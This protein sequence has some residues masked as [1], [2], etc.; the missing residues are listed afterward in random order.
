M[1]YA[2]YFFSLTLQAVLGYPL[3]PSS[4]LVLLLQLLPSLDFWLF[5]FQVLNL[6][7]LLMNYCWYIYK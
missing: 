7:E 1:S 3:I 5:K 6:L 4:T 2:F